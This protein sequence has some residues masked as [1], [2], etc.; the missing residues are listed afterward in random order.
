MVFKRSSRMNTSLVRRRRN[1]KRRRLPNVKQVSLFTPRNIASGVRYAVR[2]VNMMKGIINSEI[3]RFDSLNSGG[4]STTPLF[5]ILTG[6]DQGDDVNQ[7]SGNSILMKYMT[8]KITATINSAATATLVR[9]TIF[10][11]NDNDQQTPTAAELYQTS[12]NILSSINPD[13]SARYTILRDAYFTLSINGDR[14]LMSENY[15]PLNYHA[16]YITATGSTGFGK[17]NIWA[18][19]QSTEATNTPTVSIVTRT[20]YYDN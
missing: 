14:I 16:K 7:R 10:A 15:K 18:C 12:S 8:M 9:V 4:A 13:Y 11:D 2:G 3:K 19:M 17:G 20:A 6:I 1:F 5:F